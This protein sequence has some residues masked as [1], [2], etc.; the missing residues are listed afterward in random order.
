MEN[1]PPARDGEDPGSSRQVRRRD[2]IRT[3]TPHGAPQPQIHPRGS[4]NSCLSYL[5]NL[6]SPHLLTLIKCTIGQELLGDT[7][8][9]PPCSGNEGDSTGWQCG[10]LPAVGGL[11]HTALRAIAP[12]WNGAQRHGAALPNPRCAPTLPQRGAPCVRKSHPLG[13]L[14][15]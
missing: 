10:H 5:V 14:C 4:D 1:R 13:F 3:P 9:Q 8:E 2:P 12:V 11:G 6:P 15:H 7:G